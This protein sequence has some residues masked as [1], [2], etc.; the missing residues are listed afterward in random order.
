MQTYQFSPTSFKDL[1][2]YI[3]TNK[4]IPN[5]RELIDAKNRTLVGRL[6]YYIL[7]KLREDIWQILQNIFYSEPRILKKAEKLLFRRSIHSFIP[8][9]LKEIDLNQHFIDFIILQAY[10]HAA[11]YYI[12]PAKYI[13][14][15]EYSDIVHPEIN[16]TT[17]SDSKIFDP[18]YK[19]LLT[20]HVNNLESSYS[21]NLIDSQIRQN[22]KRIK[23]FILNY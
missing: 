19:I 14:S 12:N 13:I 10:R 8:R 23:E 11:D 5:N 1:C 22:K 17:F 18:T 4:P 21:Y 20:I 6:Y 15:D 2:E 3:H 9:L 7:L 16:E